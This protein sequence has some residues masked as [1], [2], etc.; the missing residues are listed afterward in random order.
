MDLVDLWLL[1]YLET[2]YVDGPGQMAVRCQP[3]E[4]ITFNQLYCSLLRTD[5]RLTAGD[6]GG[7]VWT[8]AQGETLSSGV[9]RTSR[10]ERPCLQQLQ[11]FSQIGLLEQHLDWKTQSESGECVPTSPLLCF[12]QFVGVFSF[13]LFFSLFEVK[14]HATV[15]NASLVFL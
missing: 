5:G 13:Y 9:W 10:V 6:V 3:N 1:S 8:L 11:P 7:T 2:I 12:H 14:L 15:L 4:R